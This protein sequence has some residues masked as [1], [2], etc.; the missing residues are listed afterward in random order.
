MY[1]AVPVCVHS[2][3]CITKVG[4]LFFFFLKLTK[5]FQF[6]FIFFI[7][8]KIIK[9]LTVFLPDTILGATFTVVCRMNMLRKIVECVECCYS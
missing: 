2:K 5:S 9:A 1:I 7:Q 6:T 4:F 8:L 3:A